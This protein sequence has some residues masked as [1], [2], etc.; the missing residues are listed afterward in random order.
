MSVPR[1]ISSDPRPFH[2][3]EIHRTT[4]ENG[5]T[6]VAVPMPGKT[7]CAAELVLDAGAAFD[8][9][10]GTGNI[11]ARAFNEGTVIRDAAAFADASEG[12]G[13]QLAA[14]LS[15]D[16]LSLSLSA[17]KSRLAASLALLA[18]AAWTPSIPE[19]GFQRIKAE[20][21]VQIQQE[22]ANGAVRAGL[23]FPK[24]A[25]TSDST[26]FRSARGTIESVQK[27]TREDI[28]AHHERY[29]SP[30]SATL[31]VAGDV[32]PAWVFE[33]AKATLGGFTRPEGDRK[34]PTTASAVDST[35]IVLVDRPGSVQSNV[36]VG[37]SG[38]ERTSSDLDALRALIYCFGGSFSSRV[39]LR[40]REEL[41]YTYGSRADLDARRAVGPYQMSAP[42]QADST[43][44]TVR[45]TLELTKKVVADGLTQDELE[46]AHD[47]LAG[48]FPLRFET[49]DAVA[50]AVANLAVYGLP[51]EDLTKFPERMRAVT[52][53]QTSEVA[54][55]YLKPDA[56]LVVVVG[57]AAEVRE[58]LEA[59]AP[60]TV[61]TD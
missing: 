54:K 12:L 25:Y 5:L 22:M 9:I 42:V 61:V 31:V 38:V 24:H 36:I 23:E 4:L 37:H 6:V 10:E 43:A 20:R 44:D 60:V 7:L 47:Y 59:I 18:E 29:V 56:S 52:L 58:G 34:S 40:L 46:A 14:S 3:P 48:V 11:L 57:P 49:A 55:K 39:N 16:A 1:P 21:L 26:Y 19:D 53:E 33:N 32:D 50:A 17:P 2:F 45:E 27:L 8:D 15:W 51:D 13:M 41:G 35:R 30:A 28:V